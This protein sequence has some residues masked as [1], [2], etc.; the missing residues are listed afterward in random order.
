MLHFCVPDALLVELARDSRTAPWRCLTR[1]GSPSMWREVSSCASPL[2]IQL[3]A[4]PERDAE[5]RRVG[6]TSAA[7][8]ELENLRLGLFRPGVAREDASR[9]RG[10]GSRSSQL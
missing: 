1:L 6:G 9:L 2:P 4:F 5:V 7:A 3:S 8:T 10:R